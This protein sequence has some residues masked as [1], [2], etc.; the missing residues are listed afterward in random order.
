MG[1][2]PMAWVP[3]MQAEMAR[4]A[5]VQEAKPAAQLVLLMSWPLMEE[6]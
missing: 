2:A 1:L 4:P 3:P 5:A 6:M